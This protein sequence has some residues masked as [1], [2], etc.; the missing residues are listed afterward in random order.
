M[1]LIYTDEKRID[2][3]VLHSYSMDIAYGCDENDFELEVGIDNDVVLS[4]DCFVYF[5]GTEYG[6]IIDAME[7][8]T[9]DEKVIY[10]GRSWHGILENRILEPDANCKSLVVSGEVHDVLGILISKL[11]LNGI[12]RASEEDTEI[13]IDSYE[14]SYERGYAGI[15]KMLAS[16][17]LKLKMRMENGYV[18]LYAEPV[19]DYSQDE[20]FDITQID[21]S[22]TKTYNITN[23]IICR[24]VE[25]GEG[26]V[27]TYTI[28]LFT[29][30]NGGVQPY[31][32]VDRPTKDAHY[33]LNKTRQ[34]VFG[35][36]EITA[37]I[38]QDSISTVANYE[39]LNTQPGD[40][41]TAF[42]NYYTYNAEEDSYDNIEVKT[43]DVYTLL[44]ARPSDWGSKYANYFKY[45]DGKY[46]SV[47][48]VE[49][50]TFQKLTSRPSNWTTNYGDYFYYYT[51]GVTSQYKTAE[52]VSHDKYTKQT[53][54]PTD[55]DT[56]YTSYYRKAT[57]KEL[58]KDSKKQY[59]S[60]IAD[61]K[62]ETKTVTDKSGKKKTT[63][64]TVKTTPKWV[65]KKYYTKSTYMTAPNFSKK[66]YYKKVVSTV[67]PTWTAGTYYS[68]A[69]DQIIVPPFKK[70]T[71]YRQVLDH[72]Y[73]MV[74]KALE[75]LNKEAEE[76]DSIEIDL[77]VTQKEYDIGDI[78][79]ASEPITGMV[80]F[81]PITKKIIKLS[82]DCI[83]NISYEIGSGS[84]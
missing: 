28:H 61:E 32:T 83:P 30:E 38:D 75:Q 54:K 72:Y 40:W 80:V 31:A 19:S 34:V 76:C 66:T 17:S 41:K 68:L 12:F 71:Y 82:E 24:G 15:C 67:A 55:W 44:S 46:T 29:D 21:Y 50:E 37:F 9:D 26:F 45:R 35:V 23:H 14:F 56:K 1:D 8:N 77:D 16:F 4:Q 53:T 36:R 62:K 49:T 7:V 27:K 65:A 3:G 79:G 70:G 33:I 20:E 60:V 42:S 48:G 10:R 6:G 47:E 25:T 13:D 74:Q 2:I 81:Q 22:L 64:V 43:Q 39:M 63:T 59:Y 11:R 57:A 84:E 73:N 5:D 69:A 18:L 52:G 51:D 58:K 78:V